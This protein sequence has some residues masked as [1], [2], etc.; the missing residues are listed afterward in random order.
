[1]RRPLMRKPSP[2]LGA[3]T[4]RAMR[5]SLMRKPSPD[6]GPSTHGSTI[7]SGRS[8]G[9]I[10]GHAE[11]HQPR[12]AAPAI[13][14]SHP[15]AASPLSLACGCFGRTRAACGQNWLSSANLKLRELVERTTFA[16]VGR[17]I[18]GRCLGPNIGAKDGVGHGPTLWSNACHQRPPR[19]AFPSFA[20]D[21]PPKSGHGSPQPPRPR[22]KGGA[23][24]CARRSHGPRRAL[25]STPNCQGPLRMPKRPPPATGL[26]GVPLQGKGRGRRARAP[27]RQ[28]VTCSR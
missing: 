24:R 15:Q 8:T 13:P 17:D 5:R 9:H 14:A 22:S 4:Q 20:A 27:D 16:E 2:E 7:S 23:V 28:G 12:R 6:L 19:S 11:T 10:S 18:G 21:G 3:S 26:R 1:M 25:S